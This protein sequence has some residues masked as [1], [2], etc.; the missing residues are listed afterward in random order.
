M[1]SRHFDG[2]FSDLRGPRDRGKE[3][4]EDEQAAHVNRLE[5]SRKLTKLVPDIGSMYSK[6]RPRRRV[7][8]SL[9][10]VNAELRVDG[11]DH[12]LGIDRSLLVPL[13]FDHPLACLV[14]D[15]EDTPAIHA[16]AGEHRTGCA[17]VMVPAF[18]HGEIAA[19]AAELAHADDDQQRAA[20]RGPLS[21]PRYRAAARRTVEEQ[22]YAVLR[23]AAGL[24]PFLCLNFSGRVIGSR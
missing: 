21:G 23:G 17:L 8:N 15:A 2:L 3:W 4:P 19:C 10:P 11:G 7:R 1:S 13:G 18:I 5:S 6:A 12:V 14:L 20:V 24:H 22:E 16:R 9:G